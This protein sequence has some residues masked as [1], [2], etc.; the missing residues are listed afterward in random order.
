[1]PPAKHRERPGEIALGP[2]GLS[3]VTVGLG[4]V[5]LVQD[6]GAVLGDGLVQLSL[7]RQDATEVV[8]GLRE[9]GLESNRLAVGSDGLVELPLVV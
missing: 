9:V 1:M 8:V 4:V 7:R 6:G 3:Q 5:G 2:K